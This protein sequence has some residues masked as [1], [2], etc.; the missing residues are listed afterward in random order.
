M[1][2]QADLKPMPFGTQRMGTTTIEGL[3]VNIHA[4]REIIYNNIINSFL[5]NTFGEKETM[6]TLE[7]MSG[8]AGTLVPIHRTHPLKGG[9]LMFPP[10]PTRIWP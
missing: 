4:S 10:I 7:V 3:E 9:G 5:K 6:K 8:T 1:N 2:L